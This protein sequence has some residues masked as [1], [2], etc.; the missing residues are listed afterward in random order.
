MNLH[1][2]FT[3]WRLQPPTS[4]GF[5]TAEALASYPIQTNRLLYQGGNYNTIALNQNPQ[6]R[7]GLEQALAR[8]SPYLSSLW[9]ND[10][11]LVAGLLGH[12]VTATI[13][14]IMSSLGE[15]TEERDRPQLMRGLRQLKNRLALTVAVGDILSLLTLEQVTRALSVFAERA[16]DCAAQHLSLHYVAAAERL[17]LKHQQTE[18]LPEEFRTATASSGLII[19]GM[20][21][22]GARELNYSSDID[23]II[24]FDPGLTPPIL[25]T[26]GQKLGLGEVYQR[27][28]RDLV[29]ILATVTEDGFVY[30]TDLRLRPDPASTPRAISTTAAENYYES[31]GQNWERAAMIKARPVGGDYAAGL[32]FLKKL[33]P[34]IWRRHLDF[35]AISDIH[36]IKRQISS[37]ISTAAA[38]RMRTE[39]GTA[40]PRWLCLTSGHNVK[41]GNGGIREIEFFA[42]TQ[43]LIWGGR[44]PELRSSE[45]C[46]TLTKLAE[47]GLIKPEVAGEMIAAYHYL[48]RVE[49]RLQMV[50]DQQTH[51]LPLDPSELERFALFMGYESLAG[52][53]TTLDHILS[54]VATHYSNLFADQPSLGLS[55]NDQT[56][57]PSQSATANLVFTGNEDDPDT[58]K[59]LSSL[60]YSQ[61]EQVAEMIRGW[62]FGRYRATRSARSRELLTELIP[63]LLAAFATSLEPQAALTRFDRFLSHLPAGIEILTL[64]KANQTLL[65]RLAEIMGTAPE[66]ADI[67]SNHPHLLD[68]LVLSSGL[69]TAKKITGNDHRAKLEA[70]LVDSDGL[71]AI[72]DQVRRWAA[73]QRFHIGIAL[74][75]RHLGPAAAVREYSQIAEVIIAVLLDTVTAEFTRLHG[76]LAGASFAVLGYGKLGSRCLTPASDL[77][78]VF[79][80][81]QGSAEQS[82]GAKPLP[83]PLWLARLGQRLISALTSQTASGDL[84]QVDMRLRPMGTKGPIVSTL[85][86]F[87]AYHRDEAWFWE[88]LALT[89]ARVVASIGSNG[90]EFA[91]RSQA[92]VAGLITAPR[93]GAELKRAVIEMAAMVHQSHP[94]RHDLDAKYLAGGAFDLD[95][96]CQYLVLM[97][98]ETHPGLARPAESSAELIASLVLVGCLSEAQGEILR[99]ASEFYQSLQLLLRLTV[100]G[101]QSAVTPTLSLAKVFVDMGLVELQGGQACE[102]AAVFAALN[103][104]L[105]AHCLAVKQVWDQ[106]FG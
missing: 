76:H 42:Q 89:R 64:L 46:Q 43:Q 73:E 62:H 90:G 91:H 37:K 24:L 106:V 2:D 74:L 39:P 58:L 50:E 86:G 33:R 104:T 87:V 25:V 52:F 13:D 100:G 19:L 48:R 56:H 21:K 82:D 99:Q 4:T 55:G 40:V 102:T 96:I 105:T 72:L 49:H 15:L 10:A 81:E 30:R 3:D 41:L 66:L 5:A 45:T 31:V 51:S 75:Q 7:H 101:D 77:D 29:D 98:A 23:L 79:I 11:E 38:T 70:S 20:G 32:A 95:F 69:V 88:T 47:L 35:A 9:Q 60:G 92:A 84:Y 68:S 16:I 63:Q 83:P 78:L 54:R 59:N 27:L 65:Q 103:K 1:P 12:G 97:V 17:Y 26:D 85:D 28:A 57:D 93:D 8:F 6:D 22:L 94:P 61:P 53:E 18:Q 14:R 80:A 44:L 71:E 34:F 36:S 67:L